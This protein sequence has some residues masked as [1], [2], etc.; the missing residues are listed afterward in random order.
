MKQLQLDID[1]A[2][3]AIDA[4]QSTPVLPNCDS[5]PVIGATDHHSVTPRKT[6]TFRGGYRGRTALYRHQAVGISILSNTNFHLLGDEQ[7]LGKTLQAL[8]AMCV[9]LKRKEIDGVIIICYQRHVH[10]WLEDIVKHEPRLMPLVQVLTG[11]PPSKRVVDFKKRIWIVNYEILAQQTKRGAGRYLLRG[12]ISLRGLRSNN[13]VRQFVR[14]CETRRV[15]IVCDELHALRNPASRTTRTVINLGAKA[16][17]R[18]GLTGTPI[19][20]R[21]WDLWSQLYFLDHGKTLGRSYAAYLARYAVTRETRYGLKPMRVKNAHELAERIKPIFTRRLKKYC[22]DLPPK[23]IH[24]VPAIHEGADLKVLKFT[25]EK[26]LVA[27]GEIHGR[28]G[29]VSIESLN[30]KAKMDASLESAASLLARLAIM[31]ACPRAADAS[32]SMGTK[33]A[34]V[35]DAVRQA[36]AP[37]VV[38][39]IHRKVARLVSEQ[40]TADGY[41]ACLISGEIPVDKRPQIIN[42]FKDGKYKALVATQATLRE[43][44]TLT[45]ANHQIYMQRDYYPVNWEQSQD[46]LCRIGQTMAVTTDVLVSDYGIDLHVGNVLVSK[47]IESSAVV[48]SRL[49][50]IAHV[51]SVASLRESMRN[52]EMELH[53]TLREWAKLVAQD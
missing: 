39:C 32:L 6:Y 14:L 10:V 22:L 43:G 48:D 41:A 49:S 42:D 31:G 19:A 25:H 50:Y 18:Y 40:L 24:F 1:T 26:L 37:V 11:L 7:G 46:R 3:C 13:D 9:R 35:V 28:L 2:Q 23:L 44:E 16:A 17:A 27:L 36:L 47:R 12:P 20:N 34:F 33:Y 5:V 15:A 8:Y 30:V 4:S 29:D 53:P 21:S 51:A 52:C 38:W 45:V